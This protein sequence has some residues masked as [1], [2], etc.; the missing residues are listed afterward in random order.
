MAKTVINNY[1][2]YTV[3]DDVVGQAV[4]TLFDTVNA[5]VQTFYNKK[6]LQKVIGE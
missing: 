3:F 5:T 2:L 6:E 4:Y 1:I